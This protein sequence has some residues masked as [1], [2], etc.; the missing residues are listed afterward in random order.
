M[1]GK[2][3]SKGGI[4]LPTTL[5]HTGGYQTCSCLYDLV[6]EVSCEG[7][8]C[9]LIDQRSHEAIVSSGFHATGTLFWST[10]LVNATDPRLCSFPI[11]VFDLRSWGVED[12]SLID[13]RSHRAIVSSGS[14]ARRGILSTKASIYGVPRVY[15]YPSA[16]NLVGVRFPRQECLRH[17]EVHVLYGA[18]KRRD[19][20][21]RLDRAK[22]SDFNEHMVCHLSQPCAG[23]LVGVRFLLQECFRQFVVRGSFDDKVCQVESFHVDRATFSGLDVQG[24]CHMIR[25]NTVCLE[26]VRFPHQ[27]C[28]NRLGE[29][30]LINF[31]SGV[32]VW[33]ILMT[34]GEFSTFNGRV[35]CQLYQLFRPCAGY[36][37]GVHSH[38]QECFW[39]LIGFG[40]FDGNEC[41]D[42]SLRGDRATSANLDNGGDSASEMMGIGIVLIAEIH[43]KIVIKGDGCYRSCKSDVEGMKGMEFITIT[44]PRGGGRGVQLPP[45]Y[46]ICMIHQWILVFLLH[47]TRR[48]HGVRT[49]V[50]VCLVLR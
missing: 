3:H 14:S 44:K 25:F 39:Q 23:Y 40:P 1:S 46:L 30:D 50:L 36:L 33:T 42:G 22:Y 8:M 12:L 38:L 27:E 6:D 35:V 47:H 13:Q 49:K 45:L 31:L 7:H 5:L 32:V 9:S 26:G 20:P 17:H 29:H 43:A 28:F 18:H 11:V 21:W 24:L 2:L 10:K 48:R 4:Y 16:G 34:D 37:V 15:L 19:D 41:Q